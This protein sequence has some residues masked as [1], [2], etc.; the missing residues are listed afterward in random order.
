M[1]Y[2]ILTREE[3]KEKMDRNDSFI[4]IEVL[5]AEEYEKEHIQGA[6]NIPLK[7]VGHTV[8]DQYPKDKEIVVYCA[9]FDCKASPNA[10]QKLVNLGFTNVFD[11]PGGKADW[12]QAGLPME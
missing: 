8:K 5:D 6:V 7:E 4:L 3:L 12:K 2:K 9:H 1:E 10:A 11:Y